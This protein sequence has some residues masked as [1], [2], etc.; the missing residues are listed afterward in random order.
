M[1][2]NALDRLSGAFS[3]LNTNARLEAGVFISVLTPAM[4]RFSI[5]TPARQSAFLAQCAHESAGF[6]RFA[7]NLNYSAAGLAATWPGRFR[8]ADG[9][10]NALAL[11]YQRRPA[12]IASYVYANRMGNGDEESGDGWRFRGRGLLQ[13]TGRGMY[14]RCGDALGLPL[15]EQPDLLLQPE[16]AVLSAAWFWQSNGLN[17]LADAGAFEAITRRINGGLN[18]L[19]ERK[20]LWL[21]AQE[22]L[23]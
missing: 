9:Q 1:T 15:L 5:T 12:V 10:P 11:V 13:I 23:E 20:A 17:A 2:V 18:G 21:K 6:S 14:Q 8:G 4:S 3:A 19:A 7:E 22:A 16:Q